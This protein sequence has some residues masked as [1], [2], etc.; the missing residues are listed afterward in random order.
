MAEQV[1]E[2]RKN[3]LWPNKEISLVSKCYASWC[4]LYKLFVN[5]TAW[6]WRLEWKNHALAPELV[7]Y[8]LTQSFSHA[9]HQC[10]TIHQAT[11]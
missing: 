4:N 10:A 2:D 9:S 8:A 3:R 7:A 5:Y 1:G 6:K 11:R